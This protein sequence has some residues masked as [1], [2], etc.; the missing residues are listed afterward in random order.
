MPQLNPR[1]PTLSEPAD[2]F[3]LE[4][5]LSRNSRFLYVL[6]PRL[7]LSTPGPATLSGFQLHH[8][9]SLSSV[10]TEARIVLP[11]RAVGLAKEAT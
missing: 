5:E 4:D 6:N 2:P 3:P 11:F 9:G 1:R 8:D 7:L 10:V